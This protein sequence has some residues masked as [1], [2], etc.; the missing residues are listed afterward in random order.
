MRGIALAF[1]LLPGLAHAED[2]IVQ[3]NGNTTYITT[4]GNLA[5]DR[6]P[7]CKGLSYIDDDLSPPDLYLGV[8]DCLNE[9][10]GQSAAEM[11]FVMLARAKFDTYRVTDKTAHDAGQMLALQLGQSLL[12]EKR[13]LLGTQVKRIMD[14]EGK[15]FAM[16]CIT[17][18]MMPPPRHN[19]G[20]MISHGMGVIMGTTE[21]PLVAGFDPVAA[22][23]DVRTSYMKCPM[24]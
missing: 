12:Q 8:I 6:D 10:R 24:P 14:R 3:K 20:Y 4:P 16:L 1:F 21:P 7:G 11:Y 19:P 22:W 5:P 17:L 2:V 13:D 23:K 18:S 15:D 9:G